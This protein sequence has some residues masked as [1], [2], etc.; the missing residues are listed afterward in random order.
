MFNSNLTFYSIILSILGS[1]VLAGTIYDVVFVQLNLGVNKGYDNLESP[2]V[3]AKSTDET[4]VTE[5]TGIT[6][7][8]KMSITHPLSAEKNG[9]GTLDRR[10]VITEQ[11]HGKK[12][13]EAQPGDNNV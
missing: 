2:P 5:E 8:E 1:I 10:G 13:K 7:T 6:T 11:P 12:I 3:Y 9:Y 4:I